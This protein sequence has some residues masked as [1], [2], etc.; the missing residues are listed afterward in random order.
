[1]MERYSIAKDSILEGSLVTPDV[2]EGILKRFEVFVAPFIKHLLNRIQR[3][4]A[5]DY[6][7]GLMSDT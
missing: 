3:Q 7:K 6:M 4:K 1:M 5:A 2:Y